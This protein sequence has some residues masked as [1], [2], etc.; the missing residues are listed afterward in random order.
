M[1]RTTHDILTPLIIIGFILFTIIAV[2]TG[3]ETAVENME[4]E[5]QKPNEYS[6]EKNVQ[7]F[8]DPET[9]VQ[10][11][12]YAHMGK[13]GICPRYTAKGELMIET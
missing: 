4:Q 2:M 8:T 11:I 3:M 5:E 9:G 10:Y 12:Y 7:I 13:S 1:E 6:W